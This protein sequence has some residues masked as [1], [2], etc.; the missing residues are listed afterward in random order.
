MNYHALEAEEVLKEF[1]SK[2]EGLSESDSKD[3]LNEYGEN[4][5]EDEA[6]INPIKIF[7]VQFSSVLIYVLLASC[8]L[9]VF[10]KHYIDA[11]IIFAIVFLDAII[12]FIQQYRAEKSV[13]E[14]KKLLVPYA[15]VLRNGVLKKIK[16][17]EIVPGDILVFSEG[18][19]IAA[20]C[21][22]INS[23]Y[24]EVNEAILTG[25]SLPIRKENKKLHENAV[26]T[27]RINMLYAGTSI[28]KGNCKCLVV[29]TGQETE[30]G[31]IAGI[32]KKLNPEETQM[33]KKL[34]KFAAQISLITL[35]IS[36]LV[37]II[38]LVYGMDK[39]EILLTSIALAISAIPEGLPAVVTIGLAI[40]AKK[41]AKNNVIVRKLAAAESL[42]DVTVICT[43]KTG[44]ITE[45]KMHVAK[46]FVDNKI[47]D[48]RDDFL[49]FKNYKVKLDENKEAF[50][51]VKTSVLC[52]NARFEIK[53]KIDGNISE[54]YDI[55]GD[56]TESALVLSALELGVNKKVLSEEEPRVR[57]I[58]FDSERK[59]MSI[60]RDSGRNNKIYTKGSPLH[61]IERCSFELVDGEMKKLTEKRKEELMKNAEIMEREA[62]RVLGFA[63]RNLN[64]GE[65][66]PEAGLI[67]IGFIGMQD[68]PRK[69][70]KKAIEDCEKLGI[71]VK[72]ITGDSMVTAKEIAKQVG[73]FGKAIS[74]QELDKMSDEKLLREIEDI[75]IFARTTPQ[76]KLRI[77]EILKLKGENVAITGDGVNDTL[78]LKRADIG[79]AMG[80]RGTDVAREVSDLILVDDNFSSIVK[81]VEEGR[82]VYENTKK[83]TKF[84][85]GVNFAEIFLILFAILFKTPL[86]L[87]PIQI[88]W[89][90]LVTDSIPAIALVF[91][92]G[93]SIK[94]NFKKEKSVLDGMITYLFISGLVCFLSQL[95]LFLLGLKMKLGIE[96]IRSLVLTSSILFELLF[97]YTCRSE[98]SLIKIGIFSNKY[99]NYAFAACLAMNL[100]VI[101]TPLNSL[102]GLYSLSLKDW[103]LIMPF[104][105]SGVVLFEVWKI[106]EREKRWGFRSSNC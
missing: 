37:L 29:S 68:T 20:D 91:E 50:D 2:K 36:A 1:K 35:V 57:E 4:I 82:L 96:E 73:I 97:V 28:V 89:I 58:A 13:L 8:V 100:I 81:A 51:L 12:G 42:G 60:I 3:R 63:F 90:N 83:I 59:M 23:D 80:I 40:A 102:F 75:G 27:E 45:E 87:L 101:Y 71:K 105:F 92:K 49:Y 84:L 25:E 85:M 78:A 86:P 67:F 74:G 9:S 99:L 47:L 54:K 52:N 18:D 61:I 7:L 94:G 93:N 66:N 10:I 48:K 98:E 16:S 41:M 38:G 77:V 95:F 14:L 46:V 34:N 56:P 5:I 22:I 72:M 43:D 17:N 69:E 88:L 55:I 53:E 24:L 76:Q 33:Q 62:L 104:A 106:I 30:F 70:V 103:A 65:K 19:K 64:R 6:K 21:R 32:L 44:T 39:F 31:K 79:V 11:S 26:L 15:K